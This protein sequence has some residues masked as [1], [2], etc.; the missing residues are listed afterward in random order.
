MR[1]M[2]TIVSPQT[3]Q[4]TD[5]VL[6]AARETPIGEIAAELGRFAGLP[7]PSGSESSLG[8]RGPLRAPRSAPHRVP[9]PR[10]SKPGMPPP[11]VPLPRAPLPRAPQPR[12]P[13]PR[14]PQSRLPEPRAP[15]FRIP[16]PRVPLDARGPLTLSAPVVTV[17]PVTV[18]LYADGQRIAPHVTLAD[19]PIKDGTVISLGSSAGRTPPQSSGLVEIRIVAG[20]GTGAIYRLAAGEADIGSGLKVTVKIPGRLVAPRAASVVVDNLGGC[21]V[22]AHDGATVMLDQAPLSA[23]APWLPGQQLTVGTA[24]LELLPYRP[25]AASLARSADGAGTEFIRP[26]RLLPLRQPATFILPA[27]PAV[28]GGRLRAMIGSALSG[29]R[30]DRTPMA[31]RRA[32]YARRKARIGQEAAAALAAERAALRA[33]FPDPAALMSIVSGPRPRLW[34]RRRGDR[35]YLALRVGTADLPSAVQVI[36]PVGDEHRDAVTWPLPDGPA[37]I[38]LTERGVIGLAGPGD[39]GR[40]VGRWLVAQAAALHSPNDLRIY[41][42][43]AAA[44]G[45]SWAWVRWLPHCRPDI[46]SGT[47]S[48]SGAAGCLAQVGNNPET[49]AARVAELLEIIARRQRA[50]G[51]AGTGLATRT[52]IMVVLDGSR[53]LWALPGVMTLLREGPAVGV[54][55]ICLDSDERLLPAQCQ[56]V[57]VSGPDGLRVRQGA[58]D[59]VTACPD[60]VMPDWCLRAAR[61]IAPIRDVS[62]VEGGDGL[63]G[64]VRLLE[65]LG[66]EAPRRGAGLPGLDRSVAAPAVAMATTITERWRQGGRSTLATV[67]VSADGPFGIDLGRDGPHGLITGT[68]G[69]G[70]SQLLRSLV[71]SLAVANRPDEM[72]FVLIDYAGGGA[73][74]DCAR[75]PHTLGMIT[76]LR[77]NLVERVLASLTAELT[78]REHLLARAGAKDIEDYQRI[79]D[80]DPPDT[81]PPDTA[82]VHSTPAHGIMRAGG[83]SRIAGFGFMPVRTAGGGAPS[84]G[85]TALPRLVIVI[86]EF[87]SLAR[88]L[89]DFVTGLV[90]IAERGRS[91]GI[92]LILATRRPPG[93]VPADIRAATNLRIALRGAGPD[94]VADVIG[95]P[96]A[97]RI[98]KDTPGRGYAR[99]GRAAQVPFQAG[100]IGGPRPDLG[101]AD[102]A[103]SEGTARRP[104]R[105]ARADWA[106]AGQPAPLPPAPL[107]PA[108]RHA[109]DETADLAVL[110]GEIWRAAAGLSIPQRRPPWQPPLP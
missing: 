27:P 106:R 91:L 9:A 80:T 47:W 103:R 62:A 87:E 24:V 54:Y 50:A 93:G 75:L 29:R 33:Q 30:P 36:D 73:F 56:A 84:W 51:L 65:V 66:L 107:S 49:V 86:D 23:P 82:Q 11:R 67:G 35:D 57:A 85:I 38:A 72:A 13:Q 25:P 90:H 74:A 22:T 101:P 69:S 34:E 108:S 97:A 15:Q 52:D 40:G 37:T 95:E 14:L 96:D 31:A 28:G 32:E 4:S 12:A 78:R 105:V 41:V 6:D 60:R 42:I 10:G 16:Q 110:V 70:K 104:V 94:E 63:P 19:S 46:G 3:R 1:L 7:L 18:A 68:A 8:S 61:A 39:S 64:S 58:A 89:P 109:E 88:E 76:H 98:T 17:D 53:E 71:A 79:R 59:P 48:A 92:H 45:K 5:I 100:L 83:T 55:G 102:D 99:L 81:D 43:A 77:P 20:P 44:G 2:L 26:P 21:L